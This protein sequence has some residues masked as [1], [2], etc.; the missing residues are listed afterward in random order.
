[1]VPE[2]LNRLLKRHLAHLSL[3]FNEHFELKN[4]LNQCRGK[5]LLFIVGHFHSGLP[6]GVCLSFKPARFCPSHRVI[7]GCGGMG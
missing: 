4:C 7:E 5:A 2:G 1:M 6:A 3:S